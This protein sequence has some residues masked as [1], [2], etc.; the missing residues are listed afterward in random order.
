MH[1]CF[2][3][4]CNGGV[5]F[6]LDWDKAGVY[7]FAALQSPAGRELLRRSGRRPD[8]ISSIVLVEPRA[9]HTKAAAI[10]RIAARLRAP[11]PL[12]AGALDAAF[13]RFIKDAVY[14]TVAA[15]RWGL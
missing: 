9:S 2:A 3:R 10:L 12:V 11:L 4:R 8:D 6:M 13:P 1:V 7:R 15:N 14:D 5:N